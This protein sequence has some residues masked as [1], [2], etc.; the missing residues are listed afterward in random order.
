ML[1]KMQKLYIYQKQYNQNGCRK[2][3]IQH[4]GWI[5]LQE[6]P[7][8]KSLYQKQKKQWQLKQHQEEMLLQLI[9][10]LFLILMYIMMQFSKELLSKKLQLQ[11]QVVLQ[12]C[13]L[14]INMHI[15]EKYFLM[16]QQKIVLKLLEKQLK[17]NQLEMVILEILLLKVLLIIQKFSKILPKNI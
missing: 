17:K 1:I 4:S 5:V 13:L 6:K 15:Q 2:Q 8:L 9:W 10:Q 12:E 16:M 7:A 11:L 3:E 14:L